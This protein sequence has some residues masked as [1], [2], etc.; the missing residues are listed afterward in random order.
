[1]KMAPN[2]MSM[3]KIYN[4]KHG[5]YYKDGIKIKLCDFYDLPRSKRK[6]SGE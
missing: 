5:F 6:I 1:M 2:I 4:N 3:K